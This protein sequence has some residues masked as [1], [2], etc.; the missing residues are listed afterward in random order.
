MFS[1]NSLI[2]S[3]AFTQ[4]LLRLGDL[5]YTGELV[6][7]SR[8][9]VPGCI[10]CAYPGVSGDGR[11][12]IKEA[13]DKGAQVILWEEKA[14]DI[15]QNIKFEGAVA[16]YA[17]ENLI[18]Y[19]GLLAAAKYAYP[20]TKFTTI[21]VTGTNGKTSITHWL[22]Q[23]YTQMGKV[24][25]IIGTTGAGIYPQTIDYQSTTPN[26]IMLQ[27]ILAAMA[28]HKADMVALEVSSHA[29]HQGRVNGINFTTAIF[30]NLTQDHLDY[31]KDM[32]HYYLAKR[33]LFFWHGLRNA[34]INTDD[35]YGKRLYA[36]VTDMWL[37]QANL[38]CSTGKEIEELIHP[39]C[40]TPVKTANTRKASFRILTYGID[41]GDLTA[42]VIKIGL[43]GTIF[44]L[45]YLDQ[46]IECSV[47]IVGKFNIYNLLAVVGA[48]LLDGYALN[49]IVD[50][51]KK[52]TPVCGRMETIR[53]SQKP[54]VVID[55]SHTPDSLKNALLTLR[56]I[57]H[58]GKLYCIFGCGGN[59]DAAKRPLMGQLATTL[60]DYTVITSD[61]PRFED[62][63]NIIT[64]IAA[65]AA[66]GNYKIISTRDTAIKYVLTIARAGDIVL[67][68]GKGHET[69][70]EINGVKHEFSDFAIAQALL[71]DKE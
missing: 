31:H 27:S 70:Q 38:H 46:E 18:A 43:S 71:L 48:L 22:N 56:E 8:M 26:P 29:L 6:L 24:T 7:D 3:K 50:Y 28:Q 60:A 9:A 17:V 58:S 33:E 13:I 53:L 63:D 67:I 66:N 68:A 23:I 64:Q 52:L 10:F 35:E 51:F 54:L 47:P 59:R 25:G 61:N 12:Y 36:E 37:S 45:K 14:A 4:L 44:I 39:E 34:I 55:Y 2:N 30:T 62:P 15:V 21:G 49:V 1:Q 40:S 20:S 42:R 11:Q 69:Y 65:G 57:E 19:V 32:E 41:S 16:N 5:L